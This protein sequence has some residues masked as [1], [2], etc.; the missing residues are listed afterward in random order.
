MKS[1]Y[2]KNFKNIR[3][4]KLPRIGR[5]N[6]IVGKNSVGKSTLLEAISLYLSNANDDGIKLVLNSRGETLARVMDDER[7]NI[8]KQHY[9]SLFTGHKEDYSEKFYIEVSEEKDDVRSLKINQV[10]LIE[11]QINEIDATRVRISML[12]KE[13]MEKRA[14]GLNV[15]GLGLCVRNGNTSAPVPYARGRMLPQVGKKMNFEYVHTSD[16]DTEKNAMLFD[17]VSLSPEEKYIIQA[18]QVINPRITR[19]N[20]L[21]NDS[22]RK[23]EERIPTVTLEGDSQRYRLSSMGDGINRILTIILAM[24]NCRDGVLLLDEFETGLHYSVQDELWKMIFMLSEELNIQVF[25]TSHSTDCVNSF[26]RTSVEGQGML[27]RLENRKGNIVAV[28]YAD[29]KELIFA[30]NNHIEIR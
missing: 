27:I 18:L 8:N 22:Q 28:D 3:E 19:I 7:E 12:S 16:F 23:S 20:Y 13:D 6:L 10:Y 9:L 26:A 21:N 1:L 17:R 2:I 29:N 30:V 24:L 4:L 14:D 11:E 15:Y 25:A 5:V